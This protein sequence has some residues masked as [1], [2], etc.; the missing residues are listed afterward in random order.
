M[1][2]ADRD[3]KERSADLLDQANQTSEVF[4]NAEADRARAAAAPE[5]HPAFDGVHCVEEDCAVELP[6]ARL[7][8]GRIRCVDCQG[9]REVLARRHL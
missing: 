9:R 4:L 8:L 2:G 6:A 7:T 5:R 3:E 1:A